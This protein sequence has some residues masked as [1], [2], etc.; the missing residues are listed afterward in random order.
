MEKGMATHSSIVASEIPW[1]EEPSR[2][3]S[4]GSQRVR[5]DT[6]SLTHTHTHTQRQRAIIKRRKVERCQQ[7]VLSILYSQLSSNIFSNQMPLYFL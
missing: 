2:V 3:Q 4:M 1:T 7:L 6:H 5:H